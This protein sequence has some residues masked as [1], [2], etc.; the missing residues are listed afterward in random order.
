MITVIHGDDSAASRKYFLEKKDKDTHIFDGE[1][2]SFL[3]LVELTQGSELFSKTQAIFIEDFVSKRKPSKEF[4]QILD[5]IKKNSSKMDVNFWEGK[6]LTKKQLSYFGNQAT[7]KAFKI[8]Q[9]TFAFLDSIKPK[10]T[11]RLINLFHQ[12]LQNQDE[13]FIFYMMVRQFRLLLAFSE[14]HPERS[15]GSEID[16]VKRLAPWQKSKLKTQAK[17]FSGDALKNIYQRLY[18]ID[19]AYKTGR[20]SVPLQTAIDFLLMDI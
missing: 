3:E 18:E 14:R 9:T 12:T 20:L 6:E 4:D 8:P 17:L 16:E 5:Y 15:E 11:G 13:D 2:L 1:K 7:I 10:N 19:L